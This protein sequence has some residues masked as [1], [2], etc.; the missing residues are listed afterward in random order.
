[1]VVVTKGEN[2]C[3]E[4]SSATGASRFEHGPRPFNASYFKLLMGGIDSRTKHFAQSELL[5]PAFGEQLGLSFARC[6]YCRSKTAVLSFHMECGSHMVSRLH[7]GFRSL[8][9]QPVQI[10]LA[11]LSTA[12]TT[13]ASDKLLPKLTSMR[14]ATRSVGL[15]MWRSMRRRCRTARDA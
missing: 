6:R 2:L 9:E 4:A 12:A 15:V 10:S 8:A 7:Q 1:V 11:P 5:A 14:S 13:S 3:A